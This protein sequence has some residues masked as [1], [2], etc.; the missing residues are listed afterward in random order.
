VFV[1]G[2]LFII[3]GYTPLKVI[4]H[5]KGLLTIFINVMSY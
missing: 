3:L 5:G 1:Q 2:Y 4:D